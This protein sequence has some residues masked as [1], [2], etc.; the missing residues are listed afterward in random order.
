MIH[1]AGR[2]RGPGCRRWLVTGFAQVGGINVVKRLT[3]GCCTIVTTKAG[4]QNFIVINCSWCNRCPWCGWQLMTGFAH[5]AGIDVITGFSA[6]R[7]AIMAT[8]TRTNHL[9]MINRI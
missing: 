7:G 4:S 6:S 2:Y 3:T 8:E 5:I 9:I 1:R